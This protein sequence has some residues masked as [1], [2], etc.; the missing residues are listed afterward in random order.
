MIA[1]SIACEEVVME[2]VAGGNF[3]CGVGCSGWL[4]LSDVAG[5][6]GGC[7]SLLWEEWGH[8]WN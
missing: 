4:G 1:R 6:R 5:L 3:G 7:M 2:V 8:G